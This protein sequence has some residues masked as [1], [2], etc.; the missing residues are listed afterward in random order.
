MS[1]ARRWTAGEIASMCCKL[2]GFVAGAEF[3]QAPKHDSIV[4]ELKAQLEHSE[5]KVGWLL[6]DNERVVAELRAEVERVTSQYQASSI[7]WGQTIARQAREAEVSK[8]VIEAAKRVLHNAGLRPPDGGTPT[9]ETICEDLN[10]AIKEIAAIDR[11]E[12]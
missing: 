9:V 6:R 1:E 12:A 11:G 4:A 5:T 8:A 2:G 10:D 7:E 3:I